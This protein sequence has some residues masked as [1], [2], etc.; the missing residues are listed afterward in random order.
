[1]GASPI[2]AIRIG[3]E[4]FRP[5]NSIREKDRKISEPFEA[6][7]CSDRARSRLPRPVV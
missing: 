1:M 2:G 7:L 5:E 6:A 4:V 3:V